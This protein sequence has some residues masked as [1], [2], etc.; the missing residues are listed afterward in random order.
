MSKH[1]FTTQR[2]SLPEYRARGRRGEVAL[3]Y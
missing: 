2:T 1:P 3:K